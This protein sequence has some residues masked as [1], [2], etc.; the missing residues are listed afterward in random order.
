MNR[1]NYKKSPRESNMLQ[2][3]IVTESELNKQYSSENN[4][5]GD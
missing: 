5:Y 1:S 3:S 4:E 2:K